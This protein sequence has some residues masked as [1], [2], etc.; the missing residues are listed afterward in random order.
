ML[1]AAQC[2]EAGKERA[3]CVEPGAADGQRHA[4][5]AKLSP[6]NFL[7]EMFAH[8]A[9]PVYVCSLPNLKNDPEQPPERR[10]ITRRPLD[11]RLF[12][13]KWDRK[14]RGL[15]FSV[16]ALEQGAQA[17]NKGTIAETAFLHADIDFKDVDGLPDDA[18][19]KLADVLHHLARLK[20]LPSAIVCSG[21]GVHAYW[22]LTEPLPT[23][24]NIERIEAVLKLLADHLAGDRKV[25]GVQSLMRLPG[26]HNT[27]NGAWTEVEI[28]S[29]NSERQYELDD[30]Q[31]WLTEAAPVIRRK[32]SDPEAIKESDPY[33][34]YAEQVG[35]KRGKS[36]EELISLLKQSRA[37]P[38]KG[39]REPM[40]RFIGSTVG[41]GWSDL[42]IKL[43][44]APYSDGG[45]DDREIQKE[46]DYARKKFGKPHP[47]QTGEYGEVEQRDTAET[48]AAPKA[49]VD[50]VDL[51]GKF[52]PPSLPRG[53]LP[54]VL[55]RFAHDQGMDMGAD[56]S[57]IAVSALAVCGAAI[58]D[59][60][61]LQ[62]KRHHTGWLESARLWVALVGP[63]SSKKTP[64]MTVA[65]RPL[66]KIDANQARDYAE[67]RSV[68]EKL[69]KDMLTRRSRFGAFSK[70]PPSRPPRTSSR[71]APTGSSAIKTNCRDGSVPWTNIRPGAG[72]RKIARSGWRHSTAVRIRCSG[73]D[74][75]RCLSRICRSL[76]LAASSQNPFA[77]SRT[78]AS[79][80]ACC[81]V[82]C[83]SR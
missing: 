26:T 44:S 37:T 22:R 83:Q 19:G 28:T 13:S 33:S 66:R 8:S 7:K 49:G 75:A 18:A 24:Q 46:I 10:I 52:E 58:P 20:Y 14:G 70:I 80:T 79:M 69:P 54:D 39:W 4:D 56:M 68:Y 73:S 42:Q 61:K 12:T 11:I 41:K 71:T 59:N 5:A 36:D 78:T 1:D 43:A 82:C 31:E 62:V 72:Q 16:G 32:D 30:L 53:L 45:V 34:D 47:D 27:K 63:P 64:I 50:P 23:Q 40:L 17:R 25:C 9:G 81:S 60:V 55:E 77:R 76:S 48:G 29:F 65:A 2:D 38:G 74:A 15:Y 21:N 35:V 57:G 67:Q 6:I 51:W 3:P